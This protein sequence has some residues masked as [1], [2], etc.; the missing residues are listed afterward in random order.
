MIGG[1]RHV[2]VGLVVAMALAG[3][4]SGARAAGASPVRYVDVSVA[5]VWASPA[6]PGPGDRPALGNPVA[7]RSWSEGL[8]TA[9]RLGLVGRIETQ[10][11]LGEPVRVLEHRGSWSQVAVIG[12]PTPKNAI[13]YPGWVPTRQLASSPTFGV[14]LQGPIA[15]V[16]LPTALLR[17]GPS[18]LELSY[19]TQLPVVGN[20]GHD[21]LVATPGGA[22]GRLSA[23][24]VRVYRSAGAIP[25]PTAKELIAAARMFLGLRYLWGGTS[26]FG[27]DCSGL[28]NLIYRAHG[29]VI[30][31]DSGAQA[32]AGRPVAA[33]ALEPGDLVFFASDPP[34]TA[35]THVAMYIG[36]GQ[37][38]ESPNSAGAVH[39]IPLGSL[40]GEYVTAR[41]YLPAR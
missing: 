27:F 39:V 24:A 19:G 37:M 34:S 2:S 18:R 22:T 8:G 5:T 10:V 23:K 35:I 7:I 30:P 1:V 32:L 20:A 40:S 4:G 16:S 13:G 25:V 3:A 14:L 12:Q 38:I 31:R 17:T 26:A 11:L 6:A 33:N 29:V 15:V 41:R 28:V 9:A 36:D 21:V